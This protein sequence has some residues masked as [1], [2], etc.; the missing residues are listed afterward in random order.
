[1]FVPRA[2]LPQAAAKNAP[3]TSAD[4]INPLFQLV[5]DKVRAQVIT[6][7]SSQLRLWQIAQGLIVTS[8][9]PGEVSLLT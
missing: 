5:L 7:W 1:M 2:L 6:T 3:A 8:D 9:Q 4:L